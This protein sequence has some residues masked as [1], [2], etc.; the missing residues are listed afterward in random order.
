MKYLILE[1]VPEKDRVV[2]EVYILG[3]PWHGVRAGIKFLTY[4]PVYNDDDS[5]VWMYGDEGGGMRKTPVFKE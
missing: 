5:G 3:A 2:G 4:R 1:L